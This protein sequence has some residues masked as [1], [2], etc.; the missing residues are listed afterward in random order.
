MV[1]KTIKI[2]DIEIEVKEEIVGLVT[3]TKDRINFHFKTDY[4]EKYLK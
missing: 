4:I 3:E 1:K 2:N